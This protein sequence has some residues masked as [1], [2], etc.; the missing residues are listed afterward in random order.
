MTTAAGL[1]YAVTALFAGA[2]WWSRWSDDRRVEIITKPATL[3]A[4]IGVALLIDP[5][6]PTVRGWFVAA[7]VLSLAGDVFLL[8]DD[9]WFVPGL[10]SF[11]AGHVAYIG[12][13][14]AGPTW[15]WWAAVVAL[16]PV[17]L[18]VATAGRRIVAGARSADQRLVGPVVAYLTVI[19]AMLVAAAA[20]GNGWAV[21]GAALFVVS[22]TILGWNRFV[23]SSP[24]LA[25]AIMITYHLAQAALVVSLV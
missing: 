5:V 4:L 2:N 20:A 15:R 7:L 12:G 21:I 24:P 23:R 9:R 19:S 25:P 3:V 1:L 8:G 18:L 22:D 11:L 16:V 17:A 13:F 6:D 10:A 14:V